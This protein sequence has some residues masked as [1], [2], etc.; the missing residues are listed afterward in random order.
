M[1]SSNT[2][3][4]LFNH[5]G[6][7]RSASAFTKDEPSHLH[8]TGFKGFGKMQDGLSSARLLVSS[9]GKVAHCGQVFVKT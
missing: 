2:R 8:G 4:R 3:G 9:L 6:D 5:S 7:C 1:Q